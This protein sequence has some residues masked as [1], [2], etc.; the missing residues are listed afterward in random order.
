VVGQAAKLLTFHLDS[1]ASHLPQ[2]DR[3]LINWICPELGSFLQIPRQVNADCR[4]LNH[5]RKDAH[6][7]A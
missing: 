3:A 7:T 6:L 5:V 4:G 1:A 2:A